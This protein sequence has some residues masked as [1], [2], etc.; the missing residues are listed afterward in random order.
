MRPRNTSQ[1]PQ[2]KREEPGCG[3][4]KPR[5]AK[6]GQVEPCEDSM[7]FSTMQSGVAHFFPAVA[8]ASRQAKA[9]FNLRIKKLKCIFGNF[10][11]VRKALLKQKQK[12]KDTTK[13]LRQE[14]RDAESPA[15]SH[16]EYSSADCGK[17][18]V[19]ATWDQGVLLVNQL[20]VEIETDSVRINWP[21]T[22]R[23]I[24]GIAADSNLRSHSSTFYS[25]EPLDSAPEPAL[26]FCGSEKTQTQSKRSIHATMR[27]RKSSGRFFRKPASDGTKL[28]VLAETA[29][30]T[31]SQCQDFCN[32]QGQETCPD[33]P[34]HFKWSAALS[35]CSAQPQTVSCSQGV[36]FDSTIQKNLT[37]CRPASCPANQ[38]SSVEAC[39]EELGLHTGGCRSDFTMPHPSLPELCDSW[40]GFFDYETP[41]STSRSNDRTRPEFDLS[42]A[43]LI[44]NMSWTLEYEAR[45][46]TSMRLPN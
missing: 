17:S 42:F 13:T 10:T 18:S 43:A 23:E 2:F 14:C 44:E 8:P 39:P 25:Q 11:N 29:T 16:Q 5:R 41:E 9:I 45:A 3:F 36:L 1:A 32:K 28:F 6:T 40:Q 30:D 34:E 21:E 37:V 19:A 20:P 4:A 38:G 15:F 22:H 31:G 7:I 35:S 33:K 24:L 26:H 27:P 46:H 12:M